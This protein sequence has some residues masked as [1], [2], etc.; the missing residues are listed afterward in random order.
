MNHYWVADVGSIKDLTKREAPENLD[1]NAA[2]EK[3]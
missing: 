3:D 2:N 1:Y